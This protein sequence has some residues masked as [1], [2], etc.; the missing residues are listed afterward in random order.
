VGKIAETPMMK[1]FIEIKKKHPDAILLFRVGDFYETFSDD[2]IVASGILGITLTRRANGAAQFV[3]LAGFPH[4]A[5][6]TYLPKLVR[7][8][9]RV[10]ICDQL[11]DPKLTKKLVKR[12]IT[13]LVTPGVSFN[14]TVLNHK[15]N[16]F[17]C[18]LHIAGNNQY[19]ISFLDIST[20]EFLTSEGN[21]DD[22]DKLLA[23]FSPKE[24]LV[25]RG[26]RKKLEEAFGNGWLLSELED[27]IFTGDA[28]ADKLLSHFQTSGLKGFGVEN[29][30]LGIIASGAILHYLDITQHYNTAHI[31]SLKRIE[32][33]RFVRLDKFTVRSLELVHTMNEGGKTLLDVLDKT[34][35]PMG[36]RLL[37][38]WIVFP[39]KDARPVEDRLNVVENFF[40]EP[41]LKK[42]LEQQ[43]QLIGDLERIISKAAVG[44]ITPREVVQ[45]KVA[46]TA[47]EPVREAFLASGNQSLQEM[48]EKLNPCSDIRDRIA[49]EI[50]PDP[51]ALTGKGGYICN[52]VNSEL[53][54][55]RRIAFSGK[56]YLM[57]LQQRESEK[58]G[59]PSLKIAYNNVF[60]YYIEVRNTHKEKVP[61]E[62]T[63]KQTLVSAERYITEELKEYEEKILGAEEKIVALEDQ[64]YAALVE[65]M[66]AYIPDIQINA[67]IIARADCLLS[68]ANV[69]RQNNYIRP[70]I[71]NSD[72]IDIK[73]GRHPVIERQLPPDQ[74][75]IANDVY[76]DNNTQQIMIITGPNMAGK[77]ALLRQ[78]ALITLMTQIG[79]FVPAESAKIG[80]VDKIFTRVGASDNISQGE[81]TFMVEMNEAA[82]I[83][84]NL[85]ERS[86]ILFDELG[87]GTSTYDGISIAWAIV[88]Y[89]H[90]H[91]KARAKTLFATHY[92]ELNEME[93]SFKRIKNYNVSV[94]EIGNK[95]I[96][97]RKLTPGGSE[98]SFGIH[99]A[100]MAGMPQSITKRADAILAAME[101]ANRKEDIRK[102]IKDFIE[103]REGYQLSFFQLDDPIL[104][105]VRDEILN[106]DVNNLTPMDALNKLNDIKKI[107]KGK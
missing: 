102:P 5:L 44:R 82:N 6:D 107:V 75:F 87:R 23:N 66:M 71:N 3:E 97:L 92:H 8:G 39:L 79:S 28:A 76:L 53:D 58:T 10:A 15:E 64:I 104:S 52:K 41:E 38:R 74:P 48:G 105:Q 63:R 70:E 13:E 103:K 46:L 94:K 34:I 42:L 65:S 32:E 11:E 81:S 29:L 73:N 14:D 2:A 45:L 43:L 35:S 106:L 17:L 9:K 67:S 12:G 20:G 101:S 18:A 84:N 91:P 7:A 83:L 98:H 25:E 47:I 90:E 4:H 86:L 56:D 50:I 60:G 55:L 33:E 89:I 68:F 99:V 95:V 21:R 85:S 26:N 78:T 24:L 16:N 36:S 59:I 30:P 31:V 93:K 77:S 37:R 54:E 1:Q 27:W 57:Q 40:R 19:G 100:R 80:L 22:I 88:E 72:I 49:R 61:P 96:F 69:A 62:W 51:P